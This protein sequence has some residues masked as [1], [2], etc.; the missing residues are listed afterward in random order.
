[1]LEIFELVESATTSLGNVSGIIFG[2]INVHFIAVRK[3]TEQEQ[4]ANKGKKKNRKKKK[5]SK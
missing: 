1:M 2:A 5:H 4:Q 3:M